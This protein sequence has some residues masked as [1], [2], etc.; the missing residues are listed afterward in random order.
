MW[1]MRRK[2]EWEF[3][4]ACIIF[5]WMQRVGTC[6]ISWCGIEI[7]IHAFEIENIFWEMQHEEVCSIQ[8]LSP[9]FGLQ[10]LSRGSFV[11]KSRQS[12]VQLYQ[13]KLCQYRHSSKYYYQLLRT[14]YDGSQ[15]KIRV[16]CVY[17]RIMAII[18]HNKMVNNNNINNT[19]RSKCSFW[20]EHI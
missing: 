4:A 6:S 3:K 8:R 10:L 9:Y 16:W 19:N 17:I 2:N 12:E 20:W 7:I 15:C 14:S 5:I 11:Y 1:C 13:S 18:E